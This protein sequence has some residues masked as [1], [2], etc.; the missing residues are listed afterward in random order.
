M[1]Y[2]LSLPLDEFSIEGE[3]GVKWHAANPT[4]NVNAVVRQ[5]NLKAV[6]ERTY[7]E[8]IALTYDKYVQQ[9]AQRKA[10]RK[11]TK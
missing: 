8:T 11:A 7:V 10:D 6:P 5:P 1:I 4:L 3:N 2:A 9:L